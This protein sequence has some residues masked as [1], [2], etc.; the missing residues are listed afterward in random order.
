MRAGHSVPE[1]NERVSPT[2][3]APVCNIGQQRAHY[4]H[5]FPNRCSCG[6][7]SG[8]GKCLGGSGLQG[9]GR[10]G[11]GTRVEERTA[12]S[13]YCC[14][15]DFWGGIGSGYQYPEMLSRWL[16]LLRGLVEGPTLILSPESGWTGHAEIK[17]MWRRQGSLGQPG[18]ES[19]S[20]V[21]TGSLGLSVLI[22]KKWVVKD[23]P[24]GYCKD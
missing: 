24:G 16:C 7:L 4:G 15:L 21:H 19:D 17:E 20:Q 13:K 18:L 22:L 2:R 12:Q 11:L 5:S 10:S 6:F 23:L 9:G 14:R 3:Q 1:T 8:L